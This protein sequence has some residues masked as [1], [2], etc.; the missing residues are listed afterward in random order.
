MR[1]FKKWLIAAIVLLVLGGMVFAISVALMGF[2]FSKLQTDRCETTVVTIDEAF[3]D[4]AITARTADVALV[5]SE[6][7]KCSV[8]FYVEKASTPSASVENG[9]LTIRTDKKKDWT[10]SGI[11]S[12][13]PSITVSLPEN[14][15]GALTIA[16]T[17]GDITATNLSA[18]TLA[19]SVTTGDIVLK[20]V[21]C[22]D[23]ITEGTTGN[24]TLTNVMASGEVSAVRS[25][26]NI[27]LDGSDAAEL[28]LQT[29]T[30][31]IIGTLRSGK[32]FAAKTT[33]GDVSVPPTDGG[34]C[35]LQTTTGDIQ[36]EIH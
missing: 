32:T 17:T 33:T 6:D 34:K 12:G 30:G 36:I 14:V 27:Q 15:Y 21:T 26:G 1:T 9:V 18:E 25:T 16:V 8:T 2:D 28:A 31:D 7:G 35:E 4:I 29:T 22:R 23:V 19:L 10:L 24:I 20:N 11:F 3:R 5:P 13:S